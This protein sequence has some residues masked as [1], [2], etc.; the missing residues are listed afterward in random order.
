MSSLSLSTRY[1]FLHSVFL[2]H[3]SQMKGSTVKIYLYIKN[4]SDPTNY[5]VSPCCPL[6]K[7]LHS[8][9]F[10]KILQPVWPIYHNTQQ[11][12][13]LSP[14]K[15]NGNSYIASL[16]HDIKACMDKKPYM[17]DLSILKKLT[18]V[19]IRRN[20]WPN[21]LDL[22]ILAKLQQSKLTYTMKHKFKSDW[23]PR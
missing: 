11:P 12:A 1:P 4:F 5:E 14:P 15:I 13:K 8:Y 17:F 22:A 3:R 2:D 21:A 6:F 19:L 7:N 23:V 10:W 16:T 20:G 9:P 18:T